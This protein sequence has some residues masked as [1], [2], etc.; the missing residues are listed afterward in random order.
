M[1]GMGLV[2]TSSPTCSTT[3]LPASSYAATAA[4]SARQDSSPSHTGTSGAAPTNAVHRS[5][6]PDTLQIWMCEP[7]ASANHVKPSGD[8]GAPVEPT[9]RNADRS[10][11]STGRSPSLRQDWMYGADVPKYVIRSRSANSHNAESDG[12][13]G[14]PSNRTT[15]AP[16]N[17][18]EIRKFHI[19]QPVV[20]NQKNVSP[21]P[22]S[23]CSANAFRCSSTMPPCPCTMPLGSPVVPDEYSTHSGWSNG[24]GSNASGAPACAASRSAQFRTGASSMRV[25]R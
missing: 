21:G 8:S 2:I 3:S 12:W 5:V 18:P 20:V 24:T 6:P 15:V 4:P 17:R 25:P 19:I 9:A 14:L 22:R 16:T 1:D 23:Q 13:P 11:R 7:T 10:N